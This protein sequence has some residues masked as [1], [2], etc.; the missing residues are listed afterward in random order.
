[1]TDRELTRRKLLNI[2]ACVLLIL[3][4]ALLVLTFLMQINDVSSAYDEVLERLAEFEAAVASIPSKWLV[5][6]V[7]FL[8]YIGKVLIPLPITAVCVIA[9]MV[10]PTPIAVA[11][12]FAGMTL[13]MT[14]KFYWG[15][16]LGGGT[17]HKI[18]TRYDNVRRM[19]ESGKRSTDWILVLF[20]LVPYFPINSISQLYGALEYDYW[21]FILLSLLGFTPKIISYSMIGRHVYNP[22]SLA[23]M[24]PIVIIFTI[25]GVSILAVN[26]FI[27]MRLAEFEAAVASIP[28]KWLVILVIFLIYIGKVLIPLPITAVCVIAGMVFPTPIAV[29]VNFAGMTLLMTIKF[30]WGKHLGGGTIH[31][32]LTRYDN[33]RRMMESGK[34]STDWILV[35]FRLV[36]YFPINSISQLYGALEYDYWKFIL[37]SLLGFTPKIISYSMIGRHVY[38]PFSLAFMLPIVIIFTI[39]GV[40]IL[41]VNKFIDIVVN[42]KNKKTAETFSAGKDEK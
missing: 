4:V 38:N 6:L 27:D 11:V 3:A 25:S 20:R 24:L 26:K 39:S 14:I 21:K 17:I 34:R 5:I 12:N 35:L 8:I 22:F 30:Y 16:H 32:I 36:P 9:G 29:A 19:M 41:A 37:L 23:F 31:K 33:V 13:L 10:F 1:M 40:S 2:L 7:I 15:K 42:N 28:S 18:L